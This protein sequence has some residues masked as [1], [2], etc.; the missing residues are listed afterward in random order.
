MAQ[1]RTHSVFALRTISHT[2]RARG[3]QQKLFFAKPRGLENT[4]D[5]V[6]DVHELVVST[7]NKRAQTRESHF[8]SSKDIERYAPVMAYF[9]NLGQNNVQVREK[10]NFAMNFYW[11]I[12]LRIV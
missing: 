10:R 1:N 5:T 11:L 7:S 6:M 12:C 2:W 4:H 3:L 9:P 8:R